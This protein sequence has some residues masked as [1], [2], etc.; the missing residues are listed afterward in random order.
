MELA[1]DFD[2]FIGYL[3][4]RGVEFVIVGAYALAYHGAPRF[5][6]DV[7]ILVRPTCDDQCDPE[8]LRGVG[9][10][11]PELQTK[12]AFSEGSGLLGTLLGCQEV[13]AIRFSGRVD[14]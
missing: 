14:S 11:Q 3:T 2:E 9:V 13:A 7:D 5:T 8:D 6:G 4:A 1:P 12:Q 10:A